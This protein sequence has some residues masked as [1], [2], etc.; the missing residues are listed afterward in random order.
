MKRII[1]ESQNSSTIV[2]DLPGPEVRSD[3]PGQR[4]A[5]NPHPQVLDIS[6][7]SSL[8]PNQLRNC[9]LK[10]F[11]SELGCQNRSPTHANKLRIFF[12]CSSP[13]HEIVNEM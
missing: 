13:S 7:Q 4:S 12:A 6:P 5:L 8:P 3:L 9:S 2:L 1:I 11:F 10:V